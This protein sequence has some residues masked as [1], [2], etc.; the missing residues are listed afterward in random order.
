MI[1]E[2]ASLKSKT[3]QIEKNLED[4]KFEVSVEGIVIT[5][6]AKQEILD[7]KISVQTYEQ[8]VKEIEKNLLKG[9]KEVSDKAKKI[10]A[11]ETKKIMGDLNMDALKNM[12]GQ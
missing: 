1:K 4:Q 7:I 6:N 11:L 12:L 5:A 2:A 3:K 8:G 9:I 10:M